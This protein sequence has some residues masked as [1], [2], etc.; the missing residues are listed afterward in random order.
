MY[1]LLACLYENKSHMLLFSLI[2][3]V[4]FLLIIVLIVV[5]ILNDC[6]LCIIDNNKSDF[7]N[8]R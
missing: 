4:C 1:Y 6:V 8:M 2:V 5:H 3:V 7:N